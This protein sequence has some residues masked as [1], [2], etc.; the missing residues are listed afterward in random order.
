MKSSKNNALE[1][2]SD[3][4]INDDKSEDMAG[5]KSPDGEA[6]PKKLG[7]EGL[8]DME[9]IV[10]RN[11]L[12]RMTH[13]MFRLFLLAFV[14]TLLLG[15]LFI[16]RW[17]TVLMILVVAIILTLLIMY[18]IYTRRVNY[19]IAQKTSRMNSKNTGSVSEIEVLSKDEVDE[20]HYLWSRLLYV[21]NEKHQ[22]VPSFEYPEFGAGSS[23][24]AKTI[25]DFRRTLWS[26]LDWFD[27]IIANSESYDF[28]MEELDILRQWQ[29]KHLLVPFFITERQATYCI[30][31]DATDLTKLYGVCALLSPFDEIIPA[32]I[33]PTFGATTLLPYKGKIVYD[34]ILAMYDEQYAPRS[35]DDIIEIIKK[36]YGVI[37]RL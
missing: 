6:P 21:V 13:L 16:P 1:P 34:G 32:E 3:N 22:I 29:Q 24:D 14:V 27:D 35:E 17:G 26:N 10:P 4:V 2:S 8:I 37:L 5:V 31:A 28:T 9:R 7:Y 15:W 33:I 30:L 11:R 36:H 19:F 20:F 18:K 25:D 12:E 23:V